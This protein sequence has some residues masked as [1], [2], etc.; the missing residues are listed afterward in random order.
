MYLPFPYY[1]FA[2]IYYLRAV[3][4]GEHV[5]EEVACVEVQEPEDPR[6]AQD[7]V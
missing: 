2:A 4:Y 7:A 3:E 5:G 1:L 6:R